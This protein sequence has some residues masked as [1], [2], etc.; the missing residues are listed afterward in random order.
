MDGESC[1]GFGPE[2]RLQKEPREREGEESWKR[3]S[4]FF[5]SPRKLSHLSPSL[6][7]LSF[8]QADNNKGF[9]VIGATVVAAAAAVVGFFLYKEHEKTSKKPEPVPAKKGLF[10]K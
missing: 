10:G 4:S 8:L 1:E 2:K 5:C 7:L 3:E 6:S 9:K